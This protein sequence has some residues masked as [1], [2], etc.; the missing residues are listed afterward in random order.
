M[1]AIDAHLFLSFSSSSSSY[2]IYVSSSYIRCLKAREEQRFWTCKIEFGGED[3][4]EENK[5]TSRF[6]FWV[7][8]IL[9]ILNF[10]RCYLFKTVMVCRIAMVW[11][12]IITPD[13]WMRVWPCLKKMKMCR[14]WTRRLYYMRWEKL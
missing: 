5:V 3:S 11:W 10:S 7:H 8:L 12:I 2:Q 6:L 4:T 14:R 13:Q 9:S 1:V